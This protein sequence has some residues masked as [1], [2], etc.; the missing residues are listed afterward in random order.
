M[1]ENQHVQP[2]VNLDANTVVFHVKGHNDIVLDVTK[3]H[4]DILRRAAMVGM[5]QVRIV[6][7]AAVGMTDDE[8]NILGEEERIQLKYDRMEA[9][10]NHYHTGTSE[11]SRRG[12][13]EGGV[14]KS[15]TIE[16]I[17]RIKGMEYD[18]AKAEVTKYAESKFGGDNKKAL[19]KFRES[20]TVAKAMLEIK[21][22]RLP[23]P[24]ADADAMLAE[25]GGE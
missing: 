15:L 10:V 19:A 18:E 6:D 23:A 2:V 17:A 25:I 11:W 16:A 7:A 9:L 4:P 24:K 3:L 21:A 20:P 13:G 5:A 1:K 22:E 14:G 8:G 12:T